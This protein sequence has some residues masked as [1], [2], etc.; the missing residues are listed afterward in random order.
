MDDASRFTPADG[1]ILPIELFEIYHISLQLSAMTV[2]LFIDIDKFNN[3]YI[4]IYTSTR[5][6][7]TNIGKEQLNIEFYQSINP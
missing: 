7:N 1:W 4:Y 3:I 6:L 5:L 2:Q